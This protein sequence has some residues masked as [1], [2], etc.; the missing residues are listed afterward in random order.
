MD[1]AKLKQQNKIVR[2][3]PHSSPTPKYKRKNNYQEVVSFLNDHFM[4]IAFDIFSIFIIFLFLLFYLNLRISKGE[5]IQK[6]KNSPNQ[7]QNKCRMQYEIN[8]CDKISQDDNP[9]PLLIKICKK[10]ED[11]IHEKSSIPTISEL[12][13]AHIGSIV[14]IFIA[15]LNSKTILTIFIILCIIILIDALRNRPKIVV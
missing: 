2:Y 7:K 5:E 15:E 10:Y 1:D 11:C 3:S 9:P 14:Q 12:A 13:I 6:L 4:K 8:G